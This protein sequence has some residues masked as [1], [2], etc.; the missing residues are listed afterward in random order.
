MAICFSFIFVLFSIIRVLIAQEIPTVTN[1]TGE[2]YL[3]TTSETSAPSRTIVCGNAAGC[4]IKCSGELSC[5]STTISASGTSNL[6]LR[7]L[8]RYA[9]RTLT[10][11]DG[12][13]NT[14]DIQCVSQFGYACAGYSG[15]YSSNYYST[16]GLTNTPNVTIVCD[17]EI[18]TDSTDGG[19]CYGLTVY[20]Q[21][22]DTVSIDCMYTDDCYGSSFYVDSVTTSI[23]IIGYGETS[24]Y[25]T[26]ID[27]SN[28]N[29][30]SV[31]CNGNSACANAEIYPPYHS[32]YALS[33]FCLSIVWSCRYIEIHL[34]NSDTFVTNFME[35]I[36]PPANLELNACD[37]SFYCDDL[38]TTNYM[39][40]SYSVDTCS[41]PHC[42]PWTDYDNIIQST[43]AVK[44]LPNA[45]S[46]TSTND[47]AEWYVFDSAV[48]YRMISCTKPACFIECTVVD[49]CYRASIYAGMSQY[50]KISCSGTGACEYMYLSEGPSDRA[51]ILCTAKLGSACKQSVLSLS[52]TSAVNLLCTSITTSSYGGCLDMIL[53][54]ENANTVDV[55]CSGYHSCQDVAFHVYH[56]AESVVI[57]G[58]E[59]GALDSA[60]VSAFNTSY[61]EINCNSY[62]T[63]SEM[64]IWPPYSDE[65]VFSMHCAPYSRS[66]Y[67]ISVRMYSST[68]TDRFMSL[69]CP[70]TD[71]RS[72]TC[73]IDFYCVDVSSPTSM[74]YSGLIDRYYCANTNCCP[75]SGQAYSYPYTYK[76]GTTRFAL[77]NS[78]DPTSEDSSGQHYTIIS[79]STSSSSNTISCTNSAGCYI[80]CAGSDACNTFL[81]YAGDTDYLQLVCSGEDSCYNLYITKGPN[82]QA[83]INC[84][85]S[86]GAACKQAAIILNATD[87][88]LNLFCAAATAGCY[89][90]HLWA[91]FAEEV[92]VFC[93]GASSCYAAVMRFDYATTAT[94]IGDGSS[95]LREVII[96][97]SKVERL[98]MECHG[99]AACFSGQVNAP[100]HEQYAFRLICGDEVNGPSSPCRGLLINVPNTTVTANNFMSL[101]CPEGTYGETYWYCLLI[102]LC[103]NYHL[104]SSWYS[105]EWSLSYRYT[106]SCSDSCCPWEYISDMT[107]PEDPKECVFDESTG[108]F[109]GY[110]L[111]VKGFNIW[112]LELSG[113]AILD[114]DHLVQNT[115]SWTD[116]GGSCS[117]S[118]LEFASS[119]SSYTDYAEADATNI[120]GSYSSGET[121]AGGSLSSARTATKTYA[122]KEQSY[123]YSMDV[124]C[125]TATASLVAANA[126][127]WNENFVHELRILPSLFSSIYMDD[128][129]DFW[130]SYG[131]HVMKSA[132]LGGH[133]RGSIVSS[134]CNVMQSYGDAESYELCLNGAYKGVEAEG[135]AAESSSSSSN[136]TAALLVTKTQIDVKGG[137]VAT[138]ST[139]FQTFKSKSTDF[140]SWI[141]D[142]AVTPDVIGG[143]FD[144]IHDVILNALDLGSHQL[145]DDL[146]AENQLTD[147]QWRN[148]A[149]ALKEAYEERSAELI[150]AELF[151]TT[152]C[153]I[154]N[155]REGD[156]DTE[157]CQCTGCGGNDCCDPST[158]EGNVM[159]CISFCIFSSIL[160]LLNIM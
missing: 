86:L 4:F 74:S 59:Y 49:A 45:I 151:D 105:Q 90:M 18:T 5:A 51:D 148:I 139:V 24:L 62:Y 67:S 117:L 11:A 80:E 6:V 12:P 64:T 141:I 75:W 100:H 78:I 56:V 63:C 103:D 15:S 119:Y 113:N 106:W 36:C 31:E 112:T 41:T 48:T 107:G 124:S 19:S 140:Q 28:A 25:E 92:N 58:G 76:P 52:D 83:D 50:L 39:T 82:V 3:F 34:P 120:A 146:S 125:G 91:P 123:I 26:Y 57:T 66:C 65:Y 60:F 118:S 53:L 8:N 99:S 142:L 10:I 68:Y 143:N 155:C 134:K 27:G 156:V 9:C 96:F 135:C 30:L 157:T 1:T 47:T 111:F 2:Y 126:I 85:A 114:I 38:S 69:F 40:R 127:Y 101:T 131:T 43:T 154:S 147:T 37:F 144:E 102:F 29:Q 129:I 104:S 89:E 98:N 61:L 81:I 55:N 73:D 70:R 16:F 77:S 21:N 42:C 110:S 128:Y 133:V 149:N 159:Y 7:C 136:N 138:F 14:A 35:M 152:E 54:A 115:E 94:V 153:E 87:L 130:N 116:E 71:T 150:A 20:A 122:G 17:Q 13:T 44:A 22:A 158:D 84:T 121:A 109:C 33:I 23:S 97:A 32:E 72:F 95:T 46:P 88:T 79:S 93:F 137:D 160:S 132:E 108:E 145:N